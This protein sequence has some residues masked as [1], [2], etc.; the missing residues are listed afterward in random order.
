[1]IPKADC[2]RYLRRSGHVRVREH[3]RDLSD[4]EVLIRY[5][6]SLQNASSRRG[7][8]GPLQEALDLLQAS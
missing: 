1:M 7:G 3:L 5:L 6:H 2:A 4:R 8:S